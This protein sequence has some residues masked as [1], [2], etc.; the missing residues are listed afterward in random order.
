MYVASAL[1]RKGLADAAVTRFL[2]SSKHN[3]W[4]D[5]T[6]DRGCHHIVRQLDAIILLSFK[7]SI[8]S[9]VG[10]KVDALLLA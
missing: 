10:L 3:E 8:E 9:A 4:P 6:P 7:L 2:C 1:R 5:Q